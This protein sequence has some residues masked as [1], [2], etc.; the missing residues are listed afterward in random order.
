MSDCNP[1]TNNRNST[2]ALCPVPSVG[3]FS[4]LYNPSLAAASNADKLWAEVADQA[5]G[6]PTA[7][8]GSAPP[9]P[10]PRAP[11]AQETRGPPP[12]PQIECCLRFTVPVT[13]A[14]FVIVRFR[15]RTATTTPPPERARQAAAQHRLTP[16][17][18]RC[19]L[20]R[21]ARLRWTP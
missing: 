14:N 3:S 21:L 17:A 15:V 13:S 8:A 5:R 4:A 11:P 20:P 2:Q 12:P 6:R 16:P 10:P 18:A 9:L 1:Y 7:H 19:P